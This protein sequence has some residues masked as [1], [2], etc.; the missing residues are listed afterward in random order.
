MPLAVSLD[1][2]ASARSISRTCTLRSTHLRGL[3]HGAS[4][5]EERHVAGEVEAAGEP[6]AGRHVQRRAAALPL[7]LDAVHGL[8]ER[9]RVQRPPVAHA[10][11]VGDGY[12]LRPV[13]GRGQARARRRR[14]GGGVAQRSHCVEHGERTDGDRR[15]P[16]RRRGGHNC[17]CSQ[18]AATMTPGEKRGRGQAEGLQEELFSPRPACGEWRSLERLRAGRPERRKSRVDSIWA[19]DVR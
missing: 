11:E 17:C 4:G 1:P 14:R 2:S 5:E 15:W 16:A 7:V 19:G 9:P 6:G 12:H 3:E 10:A 8:A 18:A 13:L